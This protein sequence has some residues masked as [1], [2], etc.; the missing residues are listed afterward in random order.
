M[1]SEIFSM[2]GYGFFVWTSFL[3]VFI[4]CSLLYYRTKKTLKKY[5]KELAQ[6]LEKLPKKHKERITKSSKV[7]GSILASH[8]KLS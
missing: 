1:I 8:N 3:V 7:I 4:F 2:E 6:E 5:E